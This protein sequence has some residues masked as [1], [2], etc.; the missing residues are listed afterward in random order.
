M[1]PYLH[2]CRALW[3]TGVV[4]LGSGPERESFTLPK[5]VLLDGNTPTC[6]ISRR[7]AMA[8][9]VGWTMRRP[10][11]VDAVGQPGFREGMVT[12]CRGAG[13]RGYHFCFTLICR[14]LPFP[15]ETVK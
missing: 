5:V 4:G 6:W 15:R 8:W 3:S 7:D 1:L 9:V 10:A 12:V 14:S 2:V 13:P 11:L